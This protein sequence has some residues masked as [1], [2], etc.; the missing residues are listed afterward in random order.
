MPKHLE[1]EMKVAGVEV[2]VVDQNTD[3]I[4][5]ADIYN[6]LRQSITSNGGSIGLDCEGTDGHKGHLE[7]LMVQL[8]SQTVAVVEVPTAPGKYSQQ[9]REL[10]ADEGIQKIVCQGKDDILSLRR[11]LPSIEVLGP[12]VDLKD[13]TRLP[14]NPIPG[15]AA[16][17]SEGDPQRV[18]WSKQSIKKKGWWMLETSE[19]MLEE[20]GFVSYAASDAWGTLVAYEQL[21]GQAAD[22]RA[23][24]SYTVLGCCLFAVCLPAMLKFCG[25]STGHVFSGQNML[26]RGACWKPLKA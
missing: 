17:L 26:L 18:A 9:L 25:M 4:E 1:N 6:R 21:T 23:R 2:L 24:L 11:C 19:D 3:N 10:L 8:A 5:C 20:P 13:M 22:K 15:L 14:K 16:I 12:V 7:P